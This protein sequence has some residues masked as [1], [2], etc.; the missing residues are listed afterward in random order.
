LS[1]VAFAC[2]QG[3][4]QTLPRPT[5]HAAA[6]SGFDTI[7]SSGLLLFNYANIRW[8]PAVAMTLLD[9][10]V[11][12]L[13]SSCPHTWS[14]KQAFCMQAPLAVHIQRT[15]GETPDNLPDARDV[16]LHAAPLGSAYIKPVAAHLATPL[17]K[18]ISQERNDPSI[19]ITQTKPW[20][21]KQSSTELQRQA[22]I[23]VAT[24][25]NLQSLPKLAT[26]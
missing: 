25:P 15:M 16:F 5:M 9:K 20:Q 21:R 13:L 10:G 2:L 7:V 12:P 24:T 6:C 14:Q 8:Q 23:S 19:S 18:Y 3:V 1:S 4:S 11:L 17:L 26:L 22:Q